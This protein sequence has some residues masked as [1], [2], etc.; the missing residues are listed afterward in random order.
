MSTVSEKARPRSSIADYWSGKLWLDWVIALSCLVAYWLIPRLANVT[1]PLSAMRSPDRQ[2]LYQTLAGISG[3][4]LGFAIAAIAILLTLGRGRRIA[5]LR[6]SRWVLQITGT[7]KGGI[8][9]L[10]LATVILV[11]AMVFDGTSQTAWNLAVVFAMGFAV[12]RFSRMTWL[13]H[14]LVDLA[15]KDG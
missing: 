15:Y 6:E 14:R 7:F 8:R 10:A 11:L 1:D 5:F 12:S 4:L 13:L 2:V 9:S 3:A